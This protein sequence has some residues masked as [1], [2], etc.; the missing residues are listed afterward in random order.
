MNATIP[1]QLMAGASSPALFVPVAFASDAGQLTK[2]K[3]DKVHASK[4][5]YSPYAGRRFPTRPLFGDTHLHTS[6]SIDA[7]AFGARSARATPT[8]SRAAR[9]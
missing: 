3:A 5:G 6:F 4:P 9:R 7:G 8:A 2:D 1:R